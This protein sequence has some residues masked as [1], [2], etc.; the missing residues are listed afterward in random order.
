M[1]GYGSSRASRPSE[2][3]QVEAMRAHA[4]KRGRELREALAEAVACPDCSALSRR[5]LEAAL[6]EA[7]TQQPLRPS[8][9]PPTP[10]ARCEDDYLLADTAEQPLQAVIHERMRQE[11][12]NRL[13]PSQDH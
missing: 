3:E 1:I 6:H 5:E 11:G 12:S 4:Q 8:P 9:T 13:Q 2:T 7:L 10:E